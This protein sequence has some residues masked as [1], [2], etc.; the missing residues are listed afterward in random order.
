MQV[1]PTLRFR[2][3]VGLE[4]TVTSQHHCTQNACMSS[5]GLLLLVDLRPT[6]VV[7]SFLFFSL[8]L[9]NVCAYLAWHGVMIS[10]QEIILYRAQNWTQLSEVG[11]LHG[12]LEAPVSG[13]YHSFL[14]SH[15]TNWTPLCTTSISGLCK[16]GGPASGKG[17]PRPA[18]N[19]ECQPRAC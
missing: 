4:I 6:D 3:P 12:K 13:S 9:V 19:V 8:A 7:V 16:F 10:F 11:V 5:S 2:R 14:C 18:G 17:L 15:G 1:K